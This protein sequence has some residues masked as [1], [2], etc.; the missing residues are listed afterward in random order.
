MVESDRD[1]E[2]ETRLPPGE[3]GGRRARESATGED[4]FEP[5][6]NAAWQFRRTVTSPRMQ[7]AHYMN[8]ENNKSAPRSSEEI[9]SIFTAKGCTV[10][11]QDL[12]HSYRA[13]GEIF[14]YAPGVDPDSEAG[15]TFTPADFRGF[16]G[17]GY[18]GRGRHYRV[19]L[20]TAGDYVPASAAEFANAAEGRR[21][22]FGAEHRSCSSTR[23]YVHREEKATRGLADLGSAFAALGL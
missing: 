12:G 8:A 17:T 3:T 11:V 14:I 2:I 19:W 22:S 6:S 15:F 13:G 4:L 10:S 21:I 23:Y 1:A 18:D 5:Q 16:D 20:V 9:L 7:S